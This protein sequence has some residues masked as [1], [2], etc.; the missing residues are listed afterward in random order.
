VRRPFAEPELDV[1]DVQGN[2]LKGYAFPFAAYA[3]LHIDESAAGRAWL[4]KLLPRVTTAEPWGSEKPA[5]TLNVALTFAGLKA[6]EVPDVLLDGFAPEF[7]EGMALRADD[8]RDTGEDHPDNWD[9]GFGTGEASVLVMINAQEQ[10]ALDAAVDDLRGELDGSGVAVLHVETGA[11]LAGNREHFGF[12]DGFAQPAVAGDGNVSRAGDG[13]PEAHGRWEELAL[14]EFILGYEDE[15][16]Q[17]PEA[18]RGP[19][20]RNGTYMVY[21]KLHQ[22]VAEF[23]RALRERA[24]SFPGGEEALAAKIVG[25]WRDGTPVILSPD[26]SD[27]ER[28]LTPERIND[29]RYE[30]DPDGRRCPLGAHIRRVNPRDALG[31][32]ATRS[33]RHRM[34]RRGMPYGPPAPDGE[35]D[36]GQD[37]GLIFVSFGSSIRRQFEIVQAQWCGDGNIFGLGD[38]KDWILLADDRPSAKMT[39]QGDPPRFLVGQPRFVTVRAGE[40]LLVPS[41]AGLRELAA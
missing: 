10:A 38:D 41:I 40:Y 26:G 28:H 36:D 21:R 5:T 35:V 9:R 6:L 34:I 13:K 24:A 23:R 8:L 30:D 2:V 14:G 39:I 32:H 4:G 7:Q 16:Q 20:G 37:R 25:R 11:V 31:W 17:L 22:H 19:L 12:S 29:F 18:P 33:R 3:W 1:R 15:D 27:R